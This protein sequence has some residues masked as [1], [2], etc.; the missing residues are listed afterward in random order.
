VRQPGLF[1][2]LL[3]VSSFS[4]S[5]SIPNL[6]MPVFASGIATNVSC[7]KAATGSSTN[8]TLTDHAANV[9]IMIT[10]ATKSV[11]V[12]ATSVTVGGDSATN[13]IN[14][15]D[16]DTAVTAQLYHAFRSSPGTEIVSVTLNGSASFAVTADCFTGTRTSLPFFGE[17]KTSLRGYGETAPVK[18]GIEFDT[19]G[20]SMWRVYMG[21]AVAGA[22]NTISTITLGANQTE[23][24]KAFKDGITAESNYEDTNQSVTLPATLGVPGD[25]TLYWIE[26]GAPIFPAPITE[27]LTSTPSATVILTKTSIQTST[28]PQN[29]FWTPVNAIGTLVIALVAVITLISQ[30]A[31]F[32]RK[33]KSRRAALIKFEITQRQSNGAKRS[34]PSVGFNIHNNGDAHLKVR[35]FAEA[36]LDGKS[37]GYPASDPLGHYDGRG[38][39]NLN[40]G[41]GLGDGNFT[42]PVTNVE[43]D[44]RLI[45]RVTVQVVNRGFE[46]PLPL[47]WVYMRD[48][49]EWFL[50]PL[51]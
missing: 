27:Y 8:C 4:A 12:R 43:K 49:N 40:A 6:T 14:I 30:R 42:I 32:R 5:L 3:L 24:S 36:F 38:I 25:G 18:S 1:A 7:W 28:P 50:E 39:W 19:F 20:P 34:L 29:D 46:R 45:M 16:G 51:V 22:N 41:R 9:L 11:I 13:D 31:K 23:I 15:T 2:V 17:P 26:V 33:K 10:V 37:L 35:V 48:R 44:Q 21:I 47:G